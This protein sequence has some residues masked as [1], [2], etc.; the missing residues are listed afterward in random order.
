MFYPLAGFRQLRRGVHVRQTP[1]DHE[2]RKRAKREND[3]LRCEL[4]ELRSM[5]EALMP[6]KKKKS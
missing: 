2:E 1:L 4:A 5:V 3:Q 6:K